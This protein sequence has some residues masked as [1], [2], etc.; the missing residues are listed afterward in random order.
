MR[1]RP[2]NL[3]MRKYL[4]YPILL[5]VLLVMGIV[6]HHIFDPPDWVELHLEQV[7]PEVDAVYV[8]VRDRGEISPLN[9]YLAK[10]FPFLGE[11]KFGT[12]WNL[13]VPSDRREGSVQWRSADSYGILARRKS[14]EWVLWWID[15]RNIDGP[16][17]LRYILGG[18]E[19]AT[20]RITG[21]ESASRA[22]KSLTDQVDQR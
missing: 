14:G 10:I 18:G 17:S 15:P 21:I 19:K 2:E 11:A 9:W 1:Y 4:K 3:F 7:P 5:A 22:P 8:V 16:S 12:M 20:M 13:N 6:I